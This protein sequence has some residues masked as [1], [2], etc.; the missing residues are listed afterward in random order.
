M[1]DALQRLLE[2]ERQAEE[3]TH[4]ANEEKNRAI[5]EALA[6]AKHH[7][8]AF[9]EHIPALRATFLDKATQ[10]AQRTV[11]ELQRRFD[12]RHCQ[13]R[14]QAEEREADAVQAALR[15]ITDPTC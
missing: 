2:A 3:T 5:D 10:R 1:D 8:A 13:L 15:L 14:R 12:E 6:E 9:Q 4:R 7:E 11:G